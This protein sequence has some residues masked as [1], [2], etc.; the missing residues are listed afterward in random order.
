MNEDPPPDRLT[1]AITDLSDVF[2]PMCRHAAALMERAA[3]LMERSEYVTLSAVSRLESE[4][5]TGLSDLKRD[6]GTNRTELLNLVKLKNTKTRDD[7]RDAFTNQGDR[8]TALEQIVAEL[9]EAERARPR[10]ADL[11]RVTPVRFD[12]FHRLCHSPGN[13]SLTFVMTAQ[14]QVPPERRSH[15]FN[16][17]SVERV[18]AS[19]VGFLM[20]FR[21]VV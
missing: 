20:L 13:L 8:I 19:P 18:R 10:E 9:R 15:V 2:R 5:S 6:M 14:G 12:S 4:L 16:N 11:P 21:P 17:E 3:G 1:R 7:V